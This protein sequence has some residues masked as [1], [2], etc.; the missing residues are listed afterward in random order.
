MVWVGDLCREAV[1]SC[2]YLGGRKKLHLL[3]LTYKSVFL[4][5]RK[6]LLSPLSFTRGRLCHFYG[7]EAKGFL[8]WLCPCH[9]M[10]HLVLTKTTRSHLSVSVDVCQLVLVSVCLCF[11]LSL[12]LCFRLFLCAWVWICRMCLT[13]PEACKKQPSF[14]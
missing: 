5:Q 11:C 8:T 9:T 10:L 14:F 6:A 12:S 2:S 1:S 13:C 4:N 7:F 3:V